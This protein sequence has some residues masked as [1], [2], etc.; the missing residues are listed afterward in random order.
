MVSKGEFDKK[1][2]RI[3]PVWVD[4]HDE[5]PR[6]EHTGND[7]WQNRDIQQIRFIQKREQVSEGTGDV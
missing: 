7:F 1:S 4:D 5:L 2:V 3:D 6:A